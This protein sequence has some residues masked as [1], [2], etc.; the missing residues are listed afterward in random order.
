MTKESRIIPTVKDGYH[1]DL[2]TNDYLRT[3]EGLKIHSIN[4]SCPAYPPKS[5][6]CFCYE[7]E[8]LTEDELKEYQ[9]FDERAYE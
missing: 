7:V 2:A 6:G 9:V 1:F 8:V 4:C 5:S 3:L